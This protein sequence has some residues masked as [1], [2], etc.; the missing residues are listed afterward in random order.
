VSQLEAWEMVYVSSDFLSTN[1]GR[2]GCTSCH[3]GDP[4]SDDKEIAHQGI[5]AQP[6]EQADVYCSG[7]GC[8]GNVVANYANS[9]H[10]NQEGYFKRIENRSGVDIRTDATMLE[11][12]NKE[13][14][15]CH[16]S[17][18]QCHVSRPVSVGGG[19]IV[20]K[21]HRFVEPSRDDNCTACHGSRV[22]AEFMGSNAGASADIHRY[23]EGGRCT[24]CHTGNEM[25]GSGISFDY[26]YLDTDMPRCEDE[27]C[28]TQ[29]ENLKEANKY[30]EWHWAEKYVT[31]I[32]LSCHV[33]HSQEYKHCDGCHTGGAGITGSS[34]FK[35]KIAKNKF[36]LEAANRDYDYVT[37]RHIPIVADTYASWGLS[38][39]H[40]SA[41]PTWKY[42]TPHNIKKWTARTDTTGTN[43]LCGANCHDFDEYYLNSND[44]APGEEEANHDILMDDKL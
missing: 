7:A 36:N 18:G 30:H 31:G 44:I 42:T 3:A 27:N 41:E 35:F 25:H 11:E 34:Y 39:P 8:H 9:L 4:T 43:G 14:G 23:K 6:S 28:H 15:K 24:F 32:N 29:V 5:V 10:Y 1:H 12:F 26:R 33:C 2:I 17:C 13:C 22:G 37:V 16:A 21:G 20:D 19:F 40:F 38:L